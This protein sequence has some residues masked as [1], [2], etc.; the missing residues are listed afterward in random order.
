MRKNFQGFKQ[1]VQGI[2]NRLVKEE[3][4]EL[5][6]VYVMTYVLKPAEK[7]ALAH[8]YQVEDGDKKI[9]RNIALNIDADWARP[10]YINATDEELRDIL[11]HE[12]I[13]GEMRR[14]GKPS[15]DNDETFIM[16]CLK[17][18]VL[19]ND[20]SIY[21]FEKIHGRGSFGM[22]AKFLPSPKVEEMLLADGGGIWVKEHF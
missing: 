8:W 6:F 9:Y 11:R 1:H 12:L 15:G 3:F 22:F 7:D 16:E 10:F 13:H 21:V 2:V 19:V 17:R 5:G 14:Q 18:G 20:E 4:P